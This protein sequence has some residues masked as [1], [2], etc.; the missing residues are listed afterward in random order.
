MWLL[1]STSRVDLSNTDRMGLTHWLWSHQATR[2]FQQV[3]E[4][5]MCATYIFK[6]RLK[7]VVLHCICTT[8]NCLL[9]VASS[10]VSW[11]NIAD[12]FGCQHQAIKK[13][14]NSAAQMRPH[15]VPSLNRFCLL[16]L[17]TMSFF[18][19][20]IGQHP[21]SLCFQFDVMSRA[22]VRWCLWTQSKWQ[23]LQATLQLYVCKYVCPV[24]CS[25]LFCFFQI[26]LFT[27]L[28]KYLCF[29]YRAKLV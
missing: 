2:S 28:L 18:I 1:P 14:H 11:A 27:S 20:N 10:V 19:I 21:L 24:L 13:K 25:F 3:Y 26:S 4:N 29:S 15:V 12:A 5:S 17:H 6:F 23:D 9:A 7:V 22:G 8:T 16:K